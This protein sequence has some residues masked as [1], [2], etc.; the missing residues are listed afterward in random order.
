MNLSDMRDAH[1][2]LRKRRDRF[3]WLS[4]TLYATACVVGVWASF[5]GDRYAPAITMLF[6]LAMLAHNAWKNLDF[7]MMSNLCQSAIENMAPPPLDVIAMIREEAARARQH[8]ESQ[9][10]MGGQSTQKDLH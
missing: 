2:P 3:Y 5:G 8:Y 6:V 10:V 9:A 7:K 4:V 1:L